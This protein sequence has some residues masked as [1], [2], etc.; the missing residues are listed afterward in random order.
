MLEPAKLSE[1]RLLC[2]SHG[3][4]PSFHVQ[5]F[6]RMDANGD[7]Q[8]S[9]REFV[10]GIGRTLKLTMPIM[11]AR[12]VFRRI[13][14]NSTGQL[15]YHKFIDWC[16]TVSDAQNSNIEEMSDDDLLAML[17]QKRKNIFLAFESM[18]V[19]RDSRLSLN[20]VKISNASV[21]TLISI[22]GS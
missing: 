13:D 15:S 1:S 10:E 20:E 7:G 16:Q 6:K 17:S 9:E 5:A 4:D 12:A 21:H 2:L 18:D 11:H 22:F 19:N 3:S 14:S 8:I